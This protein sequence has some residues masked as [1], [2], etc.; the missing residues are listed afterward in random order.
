VGALLPPGVKGAERV[1][2]AA[3]NGIRNAAPRLMQSAVKP[4]I[5]Q[6]K[7]GDAEVAIQ[8]LLERGISPTQAG[9]AQLRQLVDD[10][11][12]QVSA[13]VAGSTAV[14]PK[15]SVVQRLGG[16]RTQFGNQVS[17]TGDLAAIQGVAD[18]FLAHPIHKGADLTVQAAQDLKRGTY[19]TLSKKYGEAGSASTEAQKDLARGLKEEISSAVPAVAPLNAEM[20]RLITTLEVAERRAL[21]E[22]NKNPVGLASLAENPMTWAMFMADK[23]AAFKA[24]AAKLIHK[25]APGAKVPGAQPALQ[26]NKMAELLTRGAPV[27]ATQ[28]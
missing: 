18:D 6:L 9:V 17:P 28:D 13:Q 24:A 11:D 2:D 20:S 4:T 10:L 1:M 27:A 7:S 16:T 8:E 26:T 5:A 14:I 25:V 23:S 3:A 21:M 19:K 15:A 12:N 22:L